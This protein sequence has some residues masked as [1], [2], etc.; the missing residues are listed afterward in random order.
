MALPRASTPRAELAGGDIYR[1]NVG[2]PIFSTSSPTRLD[3]N[4]SVNLHRLLH[5][6]KPEDKQSKKERMQGEAEK[7]EAGA[8]P[9]VA[10]QSKLTLARTLPSRPRS[11]LP[12]ARTPN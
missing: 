4:L 2:R 8:A 3:K 5:K 11:P 1:P 12:P 9:R 10:T 6:Y 7:K